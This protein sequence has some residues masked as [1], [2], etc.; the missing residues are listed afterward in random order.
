MT[1]CPF[2]PLGVF[3]SGFGGLEILRGI[4][5][6]LPL[7]D[8]LYLGDSAQA[9]Y[10]PRSQEE[11]YRFT[12]RAVD[13]LFRQNCPLVILACNTASSEALRR[14]QQDYLPR[15]YPSRRIL[16]V[17]I[18]AVQQAVALSKNRKIGVLATEATVSSGA[19][20]RELQKIDPRLSV[21]Q[22][23]APELVSLVETGGLSSSQIEPPLEKSLRPLLK[24][25]IDTLILGCTH[26]GLLAREIEKIIGSKINLVIEGPVVAQKFEDYLF[27]HPEVGNLLS[28]HGRHRFLTTG[29]VDKF[30]TSGAVFFHQPFRAEKV[31]LV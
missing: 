7:L 12:L 27:R 20:V 6:R 3:D 14:L 15:F 9:P 26:F 30:E 19:F 1:I 29:P 16:G 17:L 25:R 10:G 18:P 23:A 8:C 21:F 4:N 5:R 2:A 31:E 11:I 13:F 24:A 28:R 22:Q